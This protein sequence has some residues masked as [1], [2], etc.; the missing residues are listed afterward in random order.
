MSKKKNVRKQRGVNISSEQ[1]SPP[2]PKHRE[3]AVDAATGDFDNYNDSHVKWS[4]READLCSG[5]SFSQ[6]DCTGSRTLDLL[7]FLEEAGKKTW[8]EVLRETSG[9]HRKHHS[10]SVKTIAREARERLKEI[11]GNA[12]EE[13]FRFRLSG[14]TRLWGIR[15]RDVFC[16]LWLDQ[17]HRVYP[18][19]KE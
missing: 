18:V 19:E 16:L 14:K 10:Q 2:N 6:W 5:C 11:Y 7:G 9:G 8:G 1:F 4:I 3:A 13:L 17:E 15:R 12:P